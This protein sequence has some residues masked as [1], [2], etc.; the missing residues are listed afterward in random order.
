MDEE[1]DHLADVGV[2]V[3]KHAPLLVAKAKDERDLAES[4]AAA[5]FR[6]TVPHATREAIRRSGVSDV[7]YASCSWSPYEATEHVAL[8]VKAARRLQAQRDGLGWA[9]DTNCT[10]CGVGTSTSNLSL[11][12]DILCVYFVT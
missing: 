11:L 1:P 9:Q 2:A 3:R 6:M 5:E 12:S 10:Q 4:K 8:Q 7:V